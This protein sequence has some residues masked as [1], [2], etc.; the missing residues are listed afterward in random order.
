M[1]DLP[2]FIKIYIYSGGTLVVVAFIDRPVF[3]TCS[4]VLLLGYL[5]SRGTK[6]I[7]FLSNNISI[8]IIQIWIPKTN[9]SMCEYSYLG[10][11]HIAALCSAYLL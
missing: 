9:N 6:L 11:G 8:K 1:A 7:N 3:L 5:C 2:F 10:A 4:S